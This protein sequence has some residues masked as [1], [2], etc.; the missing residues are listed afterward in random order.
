M[1]GQLTQDWGLAIQSK[2]DKEGS[3]ESPGE[4]HLHPGVALKLTWIPWGNKAWW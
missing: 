1:V 4:A 3:S 2:G